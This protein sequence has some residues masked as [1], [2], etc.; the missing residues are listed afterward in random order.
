MTSALRHLGFDS[1]NPASIACFLAAVLFLS[2]CEPEAIRQNEDILRRQEEELRQ[3]REEKRRREGGEG[4]GTGIER[5]EERA[6]RKRQS[7]NDAFL[8]FEQAQAAAEPRD[9]V[10]LYREGLGLCPDDDVAHYELGKILAGM[11]RREEARR[12]FDAALKINPNFK[13][14]RQ[15]LDK[16]QGR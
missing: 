13:G 14:A 16:I 4:T 10:A 9:A 1:A 5:E 12:E 11:G 8:K 7:C 2:A 6:E 15:E 3:L